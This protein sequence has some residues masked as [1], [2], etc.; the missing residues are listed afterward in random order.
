M[1][2]VIETRELEPGLTAYQIVAF[3]AGDVQSAITEI[4]DGVDRD[5]GAAEFGHPAR[6]YSI[7][8]GLMA[9]RSRGYVR[10]AA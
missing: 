10:S 5:G 2:A 7:Q 6:A 9:W 4:M 1:P 3:N 8:D